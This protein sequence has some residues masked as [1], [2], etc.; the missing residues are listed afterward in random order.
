M[1]HISSGE[2]DLPRNSS[3]R[4]LPNC[5]DGSVWTVHHCGSSPA[6]LGPTFSI[7]P[8]DRVCATRRPRMPGRCLR[9]AP[10]NLPSLNAI[11][12]TNGSTLK[13]RSL[14]YVSRRANR[15]SSRSLSPAYTEVVGLPLALD[16]VNICRTLMQH[17]L[18]DVPQS[19]IDWYSHV[20]R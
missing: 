10:W 17:A 20:V 6:G 11:P 19:S 1:L 16:S 12:G 3:T 9:T 13:R 8:H 5:G 2:E 4:H 14:S 7:G 18:S 15:P